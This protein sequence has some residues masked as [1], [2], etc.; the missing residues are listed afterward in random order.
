MYWNIGVSEYRYRLKCTGVSGLS[1]KCVSEYIGISVS[2]EVFIGVSVSSVKCVAEYQSIGIVC[3][4]CI[5]VSVLSVKCVSEY[6][7]IWYCL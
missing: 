7:S 2:S 6:K 1:V 3:K 4:V 5:G